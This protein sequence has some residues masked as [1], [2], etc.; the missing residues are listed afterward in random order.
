MQSNRQISGKPDEIGR[1]LGK[2]GC[3]QLAKRAEV[4]QHQG[5]SK[6]GRSQLRWE[7]CVRRDMRTSGEDE[8]WKEGAAD[9]KLWKERTE[10]VD[11][12]YFT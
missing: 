5:S 2:D 8:R 1:P 11:L 7:D 4:E 6:S 3:R 9:R 10:R 12:Q